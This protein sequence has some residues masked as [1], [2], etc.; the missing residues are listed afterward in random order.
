MRVFVTG[1]SGHIGSAVIS[2]LIT[3]GHEP[4]GL[5]RSEASASTVEALG[6]KVQRGD[7]TDLDG[8]REAAANADAVIHLAFDH[9]LIPAGKFA[10]A[11]AGDLAAV[12]AMC[13]AL[14]GTGKAFIAVGA[15]RS[16]DPAREAALSANPRSAVWRA[17]ESYTDRGV[18]TVLVGVPSVTHSARDRHGFIPQLI[19]IARETGVSAYA[20]EGTNTWPAGHTLDVARLFA[21]AVEKAPAG[22]QLM[23]AAEPGIPVRTIAE[24]IATHL[25]IETRSLPAD[26]AAAH[27]KTFPFI[28]LNLTMPDA[29]TRALLGWE[30]THL[31]LL[32]DMDANYFGE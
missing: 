29:G 17:I 19:Q 10:E 28:T 24:S 20:D 32:A 26:Q 16:D 8:L 1:A 30:P 23:A 7:L 22:S 14:E 6:A 18:R 9:A 27:F 2:E 15:K 13:G 4:V 5:A 11:A 3:A 21:L 31:G 25:G 12:N